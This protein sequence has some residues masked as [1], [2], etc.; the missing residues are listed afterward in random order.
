MLFVV[1]HTVEMPQRFDAGG[2][3]FFI[4]RRGAVATRG[5]FPEVVND[6][7]GGCQRL[8][9]IVKSESRQFGNTKLFPQDTLGIV[10]L[11]N[12]IFE[13]RFHP[14]NPFQK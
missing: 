5:I 12:P 10:T 2:I 1:A 7:A 11:K 4:W 13:S 9:M 14:A 6:G 3:H 8:R